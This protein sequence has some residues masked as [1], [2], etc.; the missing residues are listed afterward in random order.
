LE[1]TVPLES[2]A[3]TK[4]IE[5]HVAGV[6][7][8][9]I[10]GDRNMITTVIRNLLS[11]AIKFSNPKSMVRIEARKSNNQIELKIIDTGIGIEA[12]NI[13]KLFKIEEHFTSMGTEREKGTGLGLIL[14]KNFIARHGGDIW[15]ES[16]LQKGTTFHFTLPSA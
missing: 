8:L 13:G 15:L 10:F 14:C 3:R 2:Y 7:D 12:K 1:A 16:E 9:R 11:N 4:R 5:L 6:N